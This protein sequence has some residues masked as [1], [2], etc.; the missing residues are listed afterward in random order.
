ME[1][2]RPRPPSRMAR[3]AISALAWGIAASGLAAEP[4]APQIGELAP[5][6]ELRRLG[7]EET[8]R[9]STYRGEPVVLIFGSFT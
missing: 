9:L 1:C 8:V 6:F 7:A 2:L 3:L 5:D 4:K